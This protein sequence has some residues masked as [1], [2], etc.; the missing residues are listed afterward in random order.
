MASTRRGREELRLAMHGIDDRNVE[1]ARLLIRVI[2][3]LAGPLRRDL[4]APFW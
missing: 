1:A 4:P 2:H 3:F